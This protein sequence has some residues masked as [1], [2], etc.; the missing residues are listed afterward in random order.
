MYQ[1]VRPRDPLDAS[2]SAPY[3]ATTMPVLRL[4][5]PVILKGL[6]WPRRVRQPERLCVLQDDGRYEIPLQAEAEAQALDLAARHHPV[7]PKRSQQHRQLPSDVYIF[8]SSRH[9][10]SFPHA[11]HI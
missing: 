1:W 11:I 9:P 5:L 3:S 8:C 7:Q 10:K 2:A 6:A 4:L